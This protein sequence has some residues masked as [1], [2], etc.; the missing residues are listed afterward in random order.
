MLENNKTDLK[1]TDGSDDHR[2]TGKR[3]TIIPSSPNSATRNVN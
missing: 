1:N 2:V 3:I